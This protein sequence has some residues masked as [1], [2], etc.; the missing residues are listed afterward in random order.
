MAIPSR[1]MG[2]GVGAQAAQ[3][4]CGDCSDAL[5]ATGSTA[6]DALQ[7]TSVNVNIGTTAASTGVK[8]PPTEAGAMVFIRNTGASTL[9]IYPPT[10]STINGT[11]SATIATAKGIVCF[12]TTGAKWF[13]IAGA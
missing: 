1:L 8:L 11:T 3:N 2:S 9:T 7:L 5:T 12:A 13:T 6:A 10:G 4:I